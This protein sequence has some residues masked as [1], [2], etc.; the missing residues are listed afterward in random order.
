MNLTRILLVVFFTTWITSCA[1]TPVEQKSAQN[2]SMSW[3]SRVQTLSS[4]QDWNLKALIGIHSQRDDVSAVLQWQQQKQQ[5]HI[6]L[7]GPLGTGSYELNGQP[8][9]VELASGNGQKFY[10]NSPEAL[11]AERAGWNLPVSNLYY[12]IRG[13]P[14]PNVSAQ[15]SFDTY[16]HLTELKQEDWVIHYLSYN[17]VNRIDIPN[18]IL[19]EN[20]QLRVKIVI[21][22]WQI[23]TTN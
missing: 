4:I 18:K 20:P 19:L 22:Q 9:K 11:L 10:A 8:G 2:E 12:W 21:K 5:Y 17:A 15:K 16:N 6:T 13:L 1:T 7:F 14:V 3:D 23:G